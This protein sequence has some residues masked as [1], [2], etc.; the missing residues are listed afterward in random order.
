MDERGRQK[1]VQTLRSRDPREADGVVESTLE[2]LDGGC[3]AFGI[4]DLGEIVG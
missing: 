2:I 1:P 4:N 3:E